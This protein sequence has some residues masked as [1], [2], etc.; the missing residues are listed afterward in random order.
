MLRS[1]Y[2]VLPLTALSVLLLLLI[3][4]TLPTPAKAEVPAAGPVLPQAATGSELRH[5]A[6]VFTV[7]V[8]GT[9]TGPSGPVPDV[10]ID[11]NASPSGLP[12]GAVDVTDS[13]G[14]YSVTL[15]T[16]GSL[17][18]HARPPLDTRLVE[19]NMRRDGITGDFTHDFD[20]ARPP[21]EPAAGGRGRPAPR[22]A[23]PGTSGLFG[24]HAASVWFPTRVPSRMGLDGRAPRVRY[25]AWC[26]L[27]TG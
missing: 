24:A 10:S 20:L 19:V 26:V 9:V 17:N 15:R 4:R 16:A 23:R 8:T 11:V 2:L 7:T 21:A 5:K 12:Y 14:F 27:C 18:L 3:G 25:A 22:Q 6:D 1:P 13:N